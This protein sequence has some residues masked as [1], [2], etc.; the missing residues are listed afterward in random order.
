[1]KE[2][3]KFD[4]GVLNFKELKT[5]CEIAQKLSDSEIAAFSRR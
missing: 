1:M 4:L 3:F 2:P 5:N